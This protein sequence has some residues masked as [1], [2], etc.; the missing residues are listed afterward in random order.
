[1]KKS[2][3]T[4][5]NLF[6][7]TARVFLHSRTGPLPI[8]LVN[9][10][11]PTLVICAWFD[12]VPSTDG[13]CF[14]ILRLHTS[15]TNCHFFAVLVPNSCWYLLTLDSRFR[16]TQVHMHTDNTENR[17][18]RSLRRTMPHQSEGSCNVEFGGNTVVC[19]YYLTNNNK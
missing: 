7:R 9:F 14:R 17:L 1:M 18:L 3:K 6:H 19:C 11:H 13:V 16:F 8:R 5:I 2:N 15:E 10:L 4:P 12:F